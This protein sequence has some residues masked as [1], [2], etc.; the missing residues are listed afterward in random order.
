MKSQKND[1]TDKIRIE[2]LKIKQIR[3]RT[4][5]LKLMKD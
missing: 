3:N 4:T 1:Y 5:Q 2:L